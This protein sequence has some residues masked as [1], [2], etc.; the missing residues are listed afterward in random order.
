MQ[1]FLILVRTYLIKISQTSAYY[2]LNDVNQKAKVIKNASEIL[3][4]RKFRI[5]SYPES[6]LDLFYNL[7]SS[8]SW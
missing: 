7:I 6:E 3:D 5:Y 1:S 8:F 4:L 2:F